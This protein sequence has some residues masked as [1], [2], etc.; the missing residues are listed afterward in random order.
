ML[1]PIALSFVE[2]CAQLPRSN[3]EVWST[4]V[5]ECRSNGLKP[6]T[7]RFFYS[8]TPFCSPSC[9]IFLSS[10]NPGVFGNLPVPN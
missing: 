1:T 4:G 6:N 7:P 10:L 5:V 3:V 9:E 8:S 2:G